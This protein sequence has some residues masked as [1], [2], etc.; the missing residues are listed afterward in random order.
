MVGIGAEKAGCSGGGGI[1]RQMYPSRQ[2][3]C[4]SYARNS[5][6]CNHSGAFVGVNTRKNVA[7]GVVAREKQTVMSVASAEDG[8][9]VRAVLFDMDGVLCNSE[10]VSRQAAAEVMK[11]LYGL[12]VSPDEFLEFT[13]TGVLCLNILIDR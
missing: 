12:D 1:A 6:I 2:V 8:D 11:E 13:G 4:R 7:G 5:A 10:V 9:A 3:H